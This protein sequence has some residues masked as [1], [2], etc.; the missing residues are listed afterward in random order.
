M[1]RAYDCIIV[2]AGAM[3][4]AAAYALTQRGQR[5]LLLEQFALNHRMGSSYGHSRIIRY[6]YDHAQYVTLMRD[7][8]PLWRT[9]EREAGEQLLHRTG[10]IDF[11]PASDPRLLATIKALQASKIEHELLEPAAAQ[12][13]FPQFHFP[14]DTLVLYQPDSGFLAASAAVMAQAKLARAA[15]AQIIEHSP[16]ERIEIQDD[17][18]VLYSATGTYTADRL[19]LT[20][21]AWAKRLLR[22]VGVELPLQPLRCQLNFFQPLPSA[23]FTAPDCPVWIAHVES[24]FQRTVYGVPAHGSSGFKVAFHGGEPFD[25]PD[26]ISREPDAE[27]VA[28]LR[29]FLRSYLPVIADSPL[30]ESRICLYTQTPDEHFIVDRHPQHAHVIIAAGFSGHGFKFSIIIGQM[31]TQLALDGATEYEDSLFKLKRFID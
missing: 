16:V 3:G 30:L 4:S 11:G 17:G 27:N 24:R 26:A 5:V 12:L 9:L 8:F 13:R 18:V 14:D 31:L 22:Q 19:L 7:T 6:A 28:A 20:A 23:P 29:P 15:G 10:G 2:G 21:G 25:D 1:S